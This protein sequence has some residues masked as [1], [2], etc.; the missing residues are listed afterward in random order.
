MSGRALLFDLDG[1]LADPREGIVRC[2]QHTLGAL[3]L[4][5]PPDDDLAKL[6]GPPLR[7]TL[8]EL[9]GP[10]RRHMAADALAMF[11]ERFAEKG[12]LE[13]TVYPGVHEGLRRLRAAGW[14]LFVA[15]SKPRVYAEK[16][17]V[18]FEL[19]QHLTAVHGA[20]LTGE[21]ETK[22][23]LILHILETEGIARDGAWMVGDRKYD[24]EGARANGLPCFGVLWGYGSR[25][26][27]TDAGANA[28]F[29]RFDDLVDALLR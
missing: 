1:T 13:N 21:R 10:E 7:G 23:D 6:I 11:R 3:G 24:V 25:E 16:I 17:A 20:E 5:I 8:T 26:E 18:H 19:H 28:L 12:I 27:L 2:F 4:P 29:E 9:L 15:T 22:A 14:R